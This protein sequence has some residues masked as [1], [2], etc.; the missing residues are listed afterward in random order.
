MF[1]TTHPL[2]WPFVNLQVSETVYD[3]FARIISTAL[4]YPSDLLFSRTIPSGQNEMKD[5]QHIRQKQ[6]P[7]KRFCQNR[8]T[9]VT[10]KSLSD[11]DPYLY[12]S[13]SHI[14]SINTIVCVKTNVVNCQRLRIQLSW[15]P[16]INAARN[17]L[18]KQKAYTYLVDM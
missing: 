15:P 13:Q 8:A 6:Q 2:L 16:L 3:T 9:N 5:E 11:T 4:R 18:G 17:V 7:R 14:D 12:L 1:H 10:S